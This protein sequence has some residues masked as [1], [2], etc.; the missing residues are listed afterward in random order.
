M[1]LVQQRRKPAPG[2]AGNALA[3]PR[4][5]HRHAVRRLTAPARRRL[6]SGVHAGQ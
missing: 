4:T 1:S 5:V 3:T 6:R 2:A